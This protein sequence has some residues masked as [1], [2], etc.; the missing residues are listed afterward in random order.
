MLTLLTACQLAIQKNVFELKEKSAADAPAD[1]WDKFWTIP[2][3]VD[4]FFAVRPSLRRAC[5]LTFTEPV[6]R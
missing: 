1:F 5:S 2:A 3:S 6:Q 4:D